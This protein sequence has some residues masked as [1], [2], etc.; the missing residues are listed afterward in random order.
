[1]RKRTI[2]LLAAISA[3]SFTTSSI[4]VARR[5]SNAPE[6]AGF[7]PQ[8]SDLFLAHEGGGVHRVT[9]TVDMTGAPEW[10]AY[11]LGVRV[12]RRAG[13]LAD[14]TYVAPFRVPAGSSHR[15][16]ISERVELGREAGSVEVVLIE[17]GGGGVI[18][19]AFL[20]P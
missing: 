17:H 4:I 5:G 14:E 6:A 12:H 10:A 19:N 15:A 20:K 13:G 11:Y 3:A 1:M 2:L 16:R 9:A 8:L 7:A 18:A